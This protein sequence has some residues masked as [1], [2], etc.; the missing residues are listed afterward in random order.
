MGLNDLPFLFVAD[1]LEALFFGG[2]F[3]LAELVIIDGEQAFVAK[4]VGSFIEAG[5]VV[6]GDGE[7]AR[8]GFELGEHGAAGGS[9]VAEEK[10][11]WLGVFWG[12]FELGGRLG[13]TVL[14]GGAGFF[15]PGTVGL[16]RE[17]RVKRTGNAFPGRHTRLWRRHF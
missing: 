4:V 10:V 11:L 17:Y 12:G 13:E 1:D 15:V 16:E 8:I 7:N 9:I 2:E 14:A 5:F 6:I 3:D